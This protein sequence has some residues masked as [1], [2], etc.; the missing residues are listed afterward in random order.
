MFSCVIKP[1]RIIEQAMR[2]M[3]LTSRSF[4]NYQ[5]ICTEA[6]VN[7]MKTTHIAQSTFAFV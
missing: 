6:K 7:S 5:N 1:S 4:T 3:N 2:I